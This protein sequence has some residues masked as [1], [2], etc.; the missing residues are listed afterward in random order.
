MLRWESSKCF[1]GSRRMSITTQPCRQIEWGI[2]MV[3]GAKPSESFQISCLSTMSRHEPS[4]GIANLG[5]EPTLVN[6]FLPQ[7]VS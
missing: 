6:V 2:S 1:P 4:Q 7:K 5:C 3:D